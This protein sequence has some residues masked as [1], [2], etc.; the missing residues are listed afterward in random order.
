MVQDKVL[1]EE[2]PKSFE[3]LIKEVH[4][5]GICGQCGGCVSFCSADQI[6]A[7]EMQEDGPPVYINEDN[8]LHCGICY[9]ICPQI[10]VLD[11]ELHE[12]FNWKPPIGNWKYISSAQA[13]SKQI[14]D[15]ATDGGVVTAIL[16]YL[17]DKKLIDGALISKKITPFSREPLFASTK[18]ELIEGAGSKFDI[19]EPTLKLSKYT[20][21]TSTIR[22]LKRAVD[23]D[24]MSIAIV[25]VPCQ[26]H[27]I[28]KM[29]EIGI[30]P[31]HII[32]YTLGLF[33]YENF[34]FKDRNKLED[35]F[36]FSIDD[37]V[38]MNIKEDFIFSLKGGRTI[39][40]PFSEMK[41][42]RRSACTVCNDF[43]NIYADISF[44]G[45]GSKANYTTSLVRTKLGEKLYQGAL[46]NGYIIEDPESKDSI[47]KSKMLGKII[48]FSKRKIKRSEKRLAE[49]K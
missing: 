46:K 18:D 43:S 17:L 12:R 32:K 41:E 6:G 20:T 5:L 4:E 36:N 8:C 39:H 1:N 31:A 25:G 13:I 29:Q 30:L 49:I 21:F 23:A 34:S 11:Q 45:L 40:V 37:I 10:H 42:F 14:Q 3:D 22:G 44:G 16:S 38:K 26:I 27:T 19:Y 7:I 47:N 48:G 35:K 24:V 9:L 15:I 2:N 28:R 33:C